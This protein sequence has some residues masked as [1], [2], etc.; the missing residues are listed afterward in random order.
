MFKKARYE[1]Y[2]IIFV[3]DDLINLKSKKVIK[4]LNCPREF[5]V[6]KRYESH[7]KECYQDLQKVLTKTEPEDI[8]ETNYTNSQQFLEP[9]TIIKPC[10]MQEYHCISCLQSYTSLKKFVSHKKECVLDDN[11]ST[12]VE[13]E[14]EICNIK[15]S[16]PKKLIQHL[17]VHLEPAAKDTKKHHC[18]ECGRGFNFKT[19]FTKHLLMHKEKSKEEKSVKLRKPRPHKSHMKAPKVDI[20]MKEENG[21]FYCLTGECEEKGQS[22]QWINGLREH[23]MDKHAPEDLKSFSCQFCGKMFGTNALRNKHEDLFLA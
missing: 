23:F 22:F 2:I 17:N 16:S 7:I 1:N 11:H 18:D 15:L 13:L 20:P 12:K 10:D 21:R 4:C 9:Q 5:H 19:S 3:S 14:C 8:S 6:K